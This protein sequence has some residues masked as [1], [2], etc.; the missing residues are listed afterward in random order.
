MII[1]WYGQSC[2]RVQSGQTTIVIDPF[3]KSI[4][5]TPPKFEA[6]LVLVTHNHPD[7]NNISTIKGDYF[8]INGPG[9]Y[10]Y[11]GTRVSGIRSYHDNSHGEE[12]GLNTIYIIN[13]EDIILVHLGDLGQD[14][15]DEAQLEA[16]GEVDIV[17]VPVGGDSTIDGEKALDV[18]NQIEPKIAIPMHFKTKGSKSKLDSVDNFLKT[19]GSTGLKAEEKLTIKKKDL[20]DPEG[21]MEVVLLKV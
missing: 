11:K 10:E 14:K 3:D 8:V 4:E 13:F 9:E 1:T 2:F 15:L 17:M 7:H 12:A 19:I 18:I 6:Q 20:P 16:M 21:K 5:L